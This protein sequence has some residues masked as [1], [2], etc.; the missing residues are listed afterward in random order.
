ERDL[1]MR[2]NRMNTSLYKGLTIAI[3]D[4]LDQDVLSFSPLPAQIDAPGHKLIYVSIKDLAFGA[5]NS[6]GHLEHWGPI[7]SAKGYCP[8]IGRSCNT[9][10]GRFEIFYKEGQECK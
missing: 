8:D 4:S 6:D 5:Y 2:I 9:I 3:P 7:S 1:V 10:R